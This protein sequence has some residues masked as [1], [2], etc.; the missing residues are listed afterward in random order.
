[1]MDQMSIFRKSTYSSS[2]EDP[3]RE[4]AILIYPFDQYKIKVK[5]DPEGKFLGITGVSVVKRFLSEAQQMQK[6][7]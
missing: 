6:L 3:E 1:M 2:G 4:N 5:L 7:R